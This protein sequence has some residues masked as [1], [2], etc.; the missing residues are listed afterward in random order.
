[1]LF[2]FQQCLLA[3]IPLHRNYLL[4]DDHSPVYSVRRKSVET[5]CLW[6]SFAHALLNSSLQC[7]GRGPAIQSL[8]YFLHLKKKKQINVSGL[9][10][11]FFSNDPL[12]VWIVVVVYLSLFGVCFKHLVLKSPCP[13][14]LPYKAT[15]TIPPS[16]PNQ[17][18]CP[19]GSDSLVSLW[20]S[21]SL[22]APQ[23]TGDEA[24]W[25]SGCSGT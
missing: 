20:I 14:F 9:F 13:H 4:S 18:Y 8:W 23:C 10:F 6:E 22:G 25:L 7:C 2:P 21:A 17:T 24:L 1:M 19:L 11:F 15:R 12:N 5:L 16:H 3:G